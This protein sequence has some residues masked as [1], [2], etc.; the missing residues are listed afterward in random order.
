MQTAEQMGANCVHLGTSPTSVFIGKFIEMKLTLF[1]MITTN[2]FVQTN[3]STKA[4]LAW[5]KL[6]GH[7]REVAVVEGRFQ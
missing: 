7:C 2:N 5:G 3:L 6:T 1:V 4:T